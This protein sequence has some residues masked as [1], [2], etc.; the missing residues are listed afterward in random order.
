MAIPS[1]GAI[2]LQTVQ[3]EFGGTN[4]ISIDEYYA[5]GSF[6]QAG[7]VGTNGPVPSS[8]QIA[9]SNFYGTEKATFISASGGSTATVGQFKYHTFTGNG[10]FT[11]SSTSNTFN[12]IEYLIVAGGGAGGRQGGGGGGAGGALESSFTASVT[13]YSVSV[14]GG[15]SGGQPDGTAAPSSSIPGL[16]AAFGGGNARHDPTWGPGYSGGSGDRK[17]VV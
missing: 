7:A 14:G 8:G 13:S 2:S 3:T 10:T 16:N 15:G 1:S 17:S 5:G 11:I 9:L 4:P 12:T 6:V